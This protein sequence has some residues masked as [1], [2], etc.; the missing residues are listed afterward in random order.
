MNVTDLQQKFIE[1]YG[2]S[3]ADIRVF[4]APG[5]VNLIGEHID[6]NGGYVLPAALEFGTTL[7]I[8]E[9]TDNALQL[10]STNMAYEGTL[11]RA[12]I[13]QEKTG[14]WT[15]YPVG[16]MVQLQGK[17]VQVTRGYD[18]LYHGEIPN[19]AGLSSSASLEV[20]TGYAIQSMEG[21]LDIDTVELALL[22]QK[23]EN[24]FVGVNCGIMDQFAVANG[25]KDHTI[26]LMC[27]TLEYEKV[28]FRTGAYKLIIG[29]TNKR[30][31]L[32]DSA[33]NE[34]R[35]QC[36]QALAILKEQLPAL[37]YLAQL[38]PEQFD[39][40]QDQLKDEKVRQRAQHVVE[41][42]ARVLASVEAL[43]NND[44]QTFGQLMNASHE[45]LRDLYEVS[46]NELDVMVEE[47]QR[48]P[49]TLGARMT[50]AGFGGC[51]VS[52]VHENDVER[53]VSEVGA[54]YEARTGLKGD[55]Y[56]CGVGEGVNELK[57]AK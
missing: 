22:S 14:E 49:G 24:E 41:E 55:F 17:G 18:F 12:S 43:Q 44:L 34:R 50:G 29:N 39:T 33:Y 3:G 38:K 52:L 31:G 2:E 7:L 32:V 30:R 53:F 35:S 9:R 10:A 46:C 28:P 36:E 6:Y 11:D 48:I 40:L 45:S 4:H 19:G 51:T 13:G 23:S 8:R 54:A 16:V 27:D 20:L 57:E 47:A 5:R 1:R 37:N 56:V 26:L 21:V 15:D 25:A 42:N